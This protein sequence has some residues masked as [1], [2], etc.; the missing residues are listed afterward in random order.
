MEK[1]LTTTSNMLIGFTN[2][3]YTLWSYTTTPN[4]FVDAY[5]NSWL[6][7]TTIHYSYHKNIS[8]D[9]DKVREIYPTIPFDENLRGKHN[10]W[11]DKREEDTT[12]DNIVM[13]GKYRGMS[14]EDIA[15]K[16][17]TYLLWLLG[18]ADKK[19]T[20]DLI[21][22][23]PCVI[24]YYKNIEDNNNKL[25]SEHVVCESGEVELE[26]ISNANYSGHEDSFISEQTSV[27]GEVPTTLVWETVNEF[28]DKRQ[29]WFMVE[30]AM[31][32]TTGRYDYQICKYKDETKFFILCNSYETIEEARKSAEIQELINKHI[33]LSNFY[34]VNEYTPFLKKYYALATIGT[35]NTIKVFFDNV[36]EVN[37]MYPYNMGI[38]TVKGKEKAMRLKGKKVKLNIE[39]FHTEKYV[40]NGEG[41]SRQL[42]IIKQ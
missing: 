19:A 7:S 37:G 27:I 26:F 8:F 15:E 2:K 1:E 21:K 18:N 42:A 40:R 28:T 10:S 34:I 30:R 20:R 5:G 16:D 12:P 22:N 39:I 32:L 25:I 14:I 17:F 11:S 4:Y 41:A 9:L 33:S 38:L 31:S 13:F 6:T 23:L 3:F 24:T 35:G 36:K 29:D